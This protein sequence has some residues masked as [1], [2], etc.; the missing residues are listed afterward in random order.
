MDKLD[1]E[2]TQWLLLLG[3]M[4]GNKSVLG[5]AVKVF[6]PD[7][8]PEEFRTLWAA[9]KLQDADSIKTA[10]EK[11]GV[12]KNGEGATASLIR[13]LQERALTNYCQA[14]MRRVE[15]AKGVSPEQLL[16]LLD[17]MTTRIRAKQASMENGK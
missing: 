16:T 6:A 12:V 13:C 2:T 5:S 4:L 17:S 15:F 8:V 3:A 7:D 1:R 10:L 9:L 14:T 11:F